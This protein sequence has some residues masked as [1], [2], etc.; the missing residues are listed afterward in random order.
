M[1]I[2]RVVDSTTHEEDTEEQII[3][4]SLRPINFA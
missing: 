4:Q 3:E 1:G 2:E